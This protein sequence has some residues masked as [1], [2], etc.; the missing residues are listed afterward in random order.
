[1]GEL[2][3]LEELVE[4]GVYMPEVV[5]DDGD[6]EYSLNMPRAKELAP[7]IYWAELN[8]IDTAIL[9]AIEQGYLELDFIMDENGNIDT[10]YNVT[11]KL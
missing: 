4:L 9:E 5:N 7:E 10:L 2:V 8:A 6:I 1:M 3:T 11:D